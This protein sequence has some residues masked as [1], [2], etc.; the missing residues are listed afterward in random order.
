MDSRAQQAAA[1]PPNMWDKPMA[2][3]SIV[4]TYKTASFSDQHSFTPPQALT[5]ATTSP[6]RTLPP[7]TMQLQS[8][9]A[10]YELKQQE[11]QTQIN[12]LQISVSSLTTA[13][14]LNPTE[15]VASITHTVNSLTQVVSIFKSVLAKSS[16]EIPE[17]A[18]LI[19]LINNL[20]HTEGNK[21]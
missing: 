12:T 5:Q 6:I 8:N 21:V 1:P 9:K 20:N 7:S 4:P 2:E 15:L 10:N 3:V 19:A 14:T 13:S 18:K 16:S 11:I 17:L